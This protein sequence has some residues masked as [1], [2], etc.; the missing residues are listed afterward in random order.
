M[1]SDPRGH[2]TDPRALAWALALGFASSC[3][4]PLRDDSS[5]P[6]GFDQALSLPAIEDENPDPR[7]LEVRLTAQ[8]T[9]VSILPDRDTV[10]WSYGTGFPGP[11]LRLTAGDR[12]I[13]HFEN[14]LPEPTTVHWHGV[15]LTA[16][17]DGVPEHSQPVVEPGGTFT[18]DFVVPDAGLFWFH[19]HEHDA[20]Q[21]GFGLYGALLVDPA[22]PEPD[23][24][25]ELVIVLSDI[26]LDDDAQ[27]RSPSDGG[28]LATLFGREGQVLLA[29]GRKLP[30][31]PVRNGRRLRLRLVNA[32]K[33]R[34]FLLGLPGHTFSVIGGQAGPHPEA[35]DA[36]QVLLVPGGRV[37]VS[38]TPRGAPDEV[39]EL[40]WI[41][42]D[43][44][45]GSTE[46]RA[47]E[48]IMTFALVGDEIT[49]GPIPTPR[50]TAPEPLSA[51]DAVPV[52]VRLTQDSGP[53]GE[54]VLGINGVPFGEGED[55]PAAVGETQLWTVTNEMEWDH[56]FHLHGFFFQLVDEVGA[57]LEP[58]EWLDTANVPAEQ[59]AH[60]LVRYDNRPG[61]WMFHCH[62]LDH[63]DAGMMTMVDLRP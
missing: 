25:D 10:V 5:Q 17:M 63:A 37:D 34:Y 51:V 9:P 8:Q 11:L 46:F 60:F 4:S 13:V 32:A 28:D 7:V 16:D 18:Y 55:I 3:D 50:G 48:P 1:S 58:I 57:P 14:Q 15:R 56:P 2:S 36:D 52:E 42:F 6:P 31:L 53:A 30:E 39:V 44:G 49:Q 54:L 62:I 20:A 47:P 41:P 22:E 19:P 61:M 59:S 26:A 12:L 27:L 43:R 40:L 24:G 23:L 45:Y 33:S 38:V 29:N 21:L 35:R